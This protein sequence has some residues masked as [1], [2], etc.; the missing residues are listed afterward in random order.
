MIII[1]AP[2]GPIL[3]KLINVALIPG[4]FISLVALRRLIEKGVHWDT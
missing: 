1:K 3:I 4:F 2:I